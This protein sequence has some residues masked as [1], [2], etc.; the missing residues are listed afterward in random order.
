ME[1]DKK[2]L[3]AALYVEEFLSLQG[4]AHQREPGLVTVSTAS[5]A[6]RSSSSAS[7]LIQDTL[8]PDSRRRLEYANFINYSLGD[9]MRALAEYQRLVD[10]HPDTDAAMEAR[11][12]I[13][14]ILGTQGG[15]QAENVLVKLSN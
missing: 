9:R 8:V 5:T 12:K 13:R 14:V 11:G 1:A 10:Y 6:E 7:R 2:E 3:R 15:A 4:I